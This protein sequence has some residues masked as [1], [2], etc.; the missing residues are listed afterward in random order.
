MLALRNRIFF[1]NFFLLI[2][3]INWSWRGPSLYPKP[4]I[5]IKTG[6]LSSIEFCNMGGDIENAVRNH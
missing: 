4:S 3:I 6:P 2:I 1:H 5:L